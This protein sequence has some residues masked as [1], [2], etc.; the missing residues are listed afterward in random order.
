MATACIEQGTV[1]QIEGSEYRLSRRIDDCWQLE[2][3]KTG[4]I[5]E[6][7]QQDLL[8]RVAEQKLT[9]R[10]SMSVSRCG[11]ANCDLSPADLEL[12]KLR[13][14]YV[15]A[16]INAQIPG[17]ALRRPSTMPGEGSMHHNAL[18]VGLAFTAG[19][20]DSSERVATLALWLTT[21]VA[22][23]TSKAVTQRR[24]WSSANN[25]YRPNI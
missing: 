12:A 18:P 5:V 15:L 1:V 19:N 25:P 3:S 4:R 20:A 10:G 7:D 24:L 11:P 6:Y 22:K 17:S 9:L 23:A 8:H 2:Q 21:P 13:R 14:S 16:V